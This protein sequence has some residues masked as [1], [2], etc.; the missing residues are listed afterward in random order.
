MWQVV[1]GR[2]LEGESA[3]E[4]ALREIREETGLHEGTLYAVPHVSSF[5][6]AR[7]D[8]VCL[9]PVFAFE[10]S[11][12][13]DVVLSEEHRASVWDSFDDA[14][15]RLPIPGH[16][17]ALRVLRDDILAPASQSDLFRLD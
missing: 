15:A 9:V 11:A 8:A 6:H 2:Q 1:T 13:A 17:D 3:R 4:T 7:I 16:R 14:L 12:H 5:Y 10:V